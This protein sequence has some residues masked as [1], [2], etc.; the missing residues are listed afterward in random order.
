L[1]IENIPA[2]RIATCHQHNNRTFRLNARQLVESTYRYLLSTV[3][4]ASLLHGWCRKGECQR[5][6]L[7][8]KPYN[9]FTSFK[10]FLDE[11][12]DSFDG[13]RYCSLMF[14]EVASRNAMDMSNVRV[15]KPNTEAIARISLDIS[16]RRF[17]ELCTA[18]FISGSAKPCTTY[19]A[20]NNSP[21]VSLCLTTRKK[22][23]FNTVVFCGMSSR[24]TISKVPRFN[25]PSS[26]FCFAA[27]KP[28]SLARGQYS[29]LTRSQILAHIKCSKRDD[30]LRLQRAE[31]RFH[32]AEK[33]ICHLWSR[34]NTVAREYA[35]VMIHI[36][37][38]R[39][40]RSVG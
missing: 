35:R 8:H 16:C 30:N 36:H 22:R 39:H 13:S 18:C 3:P 29:A 6:P 14:V 5:S 11:R 7:S 10:R 4:F 2:S 33:N 17:G 9:D 38:K 25:K 27:S 21:F 26:S 20:L 37:R 15:S 24:S 12:F 40:L 34:A 32:T 1:K 19:R 23:P 28:G 31:V